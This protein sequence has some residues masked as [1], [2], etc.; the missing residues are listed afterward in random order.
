MQITETEIKNLAGDPKIYKEGMTLAKLGAVQTFQYNQALNAY[1]ALVYENG[2][3]HEVII[4]L[5]RN[6]QIQR[7]Q[8]DCLSFRARRSAC[9]HIIATLKAIDASKNEDHLRQLSNSI[10]MEGILNIPDQT[11]PIDTDKTIIHTQL[12]LN[13]DDIQK[14]VFNSYFLQF[15]IGISKSY[16]LKDFSELFEAIEKH[17]DLRYGKDFTYLPDI[18]TFESAFLKTLNYLKPLYEIDQQSN[19]RFFDGKKIYLPSHQLKD[20]LKFWMNKE[21]Q[22]ADRTVEVSDDTFPDYIGLS[23]QAGSIIADVSKLKKVVSI[24][25]DDTILVDDHILYLVDKNTASILH[26]FL[27]ASRMG[28]NEVRFDNDKKQAFIEHVIPHLETLITIPENIQNLYRHGKLKACLYLDRVN[29]SISA[30]PEFTYGN[31]SFNPFSKVSI[32]YDHGRQ[33]LRDKKREQKI[34]RILEKAEF[35][36]APSHL[37]LDDDEKIRRF[38]FEYLPHLQNIMEIYYSDSFKQI[39]QKKTLSANIRLNSQINLFEVDFDI[40]G[41]SYPEFRKILESYRLNRH[42]YRL[43][44]GS[45]L[46]LDDPDTVETL[47]M[48]EDLNLDK[49]SFQKGQLVLPLNRAFYFGDHF[50]EKLSR[51]EAFQN[52]MS[53]FNAPVISDIKLPDNLNGT[54][55]DYQ[56]IGFQWLKTLAYYGL[57]GILADDMGLGK[58]LQT[59]TYMLDYQSQ[60]KGVHLIVSPTSLVFNWQEEIN[61]FAPS[62]KILIV[63]GNQNERLE[64]ISQVSGYDIVL[65]S[66]PLLRRDIEAYDNILFD[67]CVLDE[68]QY[69][70]N[71]SSLNAQ[72]AKKI[73]ARIHFALT[74]TPIENSLSELWSIFDFILPD[75]FSNHHYFRNKY[76]VPIIKEQDE[77]ASKLLQKQIQPFILRRM[78]KDVLTELPDKIETKIPVKM[79][80]KQEEVYFSYLKESLR[81]IDQNIRSFGIDKTRFEILSRLTHLRQICNH[82]RL[83]LENYDGQSAK[84]NTLIELIREGVE[85]GHR[86]LIFSQF[87]GMLKMI[88]DELNHIELEHFYLDGNTKM[89]DRATMVKQFNQGKRSLFLISLKAGGT[90]LNLVGA[91]MVIHVDPWWNPAVEDQATD[92]AYRI[93]QH[94]TVQ[95]IKLITSHSIEEKIYELQNS[96]KDLIDAIIQPGENFLTHLSENEIYDLFSNDF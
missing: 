36:V 47:E 89:E 32:P 21:I 26:P 19:V 56:I 45:F 78:K 81:L 14:N 96:K 12:M 17:E 4:Y 42:Y 83:F 6:K 70:K 44:D 49:K 65:T 85:G 9:P 57:G 10:A 39:V 92:R 40:E 33:V 94:H 13:S 22:F 43:K 86:L 75:Y 80:P 53:R 48:A 64:K 71:A 58:T 72:A 77:Q 41:M 84:L 29:S 28:L 51:D 8:C 54:L 60:K 2:K 5:D 37:Y 27:E 23:V 91:D 88:Q 30:R 74:G 82:P 38:I 24:L 55:R 34:M 16:V 15:K 20:I 35:M 61:R 76:E 69:I 52:F 87:T 18:H 68:A 66:Y 62:L 1:Y 7:F 3:K 63:A 67:T 25:D 79:T 31:Y 59:I 95:V 73:H 93:G 90:G 50:K 46:S 11:A